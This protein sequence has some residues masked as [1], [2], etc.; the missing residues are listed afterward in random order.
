[1]YN[2]LTVYSWWTSSNLVSSPHQETPL[3]IAASGG[4]VCAVEYIIQAGAD[5]NV[6]DDRGVSV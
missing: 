6:K 5:V 3:H 2:N 1:M 4:H